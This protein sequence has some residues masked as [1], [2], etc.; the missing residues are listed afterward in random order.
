MGL[1]VQAPSMPLEI[2]SLPIPEPNLLVHPNPISS[3]GAPSGSG[4]L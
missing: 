3:I 4:P 1:V 2:V